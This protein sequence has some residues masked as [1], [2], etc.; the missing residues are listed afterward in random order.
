MSLSA[1]ASRA[2]LIRDIAQIRMDLANLEQVDVR[3]LGA[4]D[5]LTVNDLT[6]TDVTGV[7]LDLASTLATPDGSAD[8]VTLR[9]TGFADAVRVRADGSDVT[10]A[11]L[12]A[13]VR[14]SG[15]EPADHLQ[16]NTVGGDDSVSVSDAARAVMGV[17][18]DLG[19]G[20]R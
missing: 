6:G 15:A 18:V 19:T 10:V 17:D 8:S 1:N 5:S 7:D 3:A 20:Q 16:V 9:G 13:A 12:P 11:G 4:A 14:I 2:V